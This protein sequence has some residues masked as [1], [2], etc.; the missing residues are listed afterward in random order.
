MNYDLAKELM[1]AGFP[2]LVDGGIT[3]PTF[4]PTLSELIAACGGGWIPHPDNDPI[5]SSMSKGILDFSLHASLHNGKTT[6]CA[7]YS[8]AYSENHFYGEGTTPEQAVGRLY[9]AL[10][11]KT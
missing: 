10:K 5:S 3:P 11:K 8:D 1:E 9:I 7:H 6:W 4:A 2:K